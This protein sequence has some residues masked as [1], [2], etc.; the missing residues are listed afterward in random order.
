MRKKKLQM[1]IN[2]SVANNSQNSIIQYEIETN[3]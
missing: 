3:Y 2:P 1:E